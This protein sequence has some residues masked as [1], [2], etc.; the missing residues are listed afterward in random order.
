M[1]R[2]EVRVTGRAGWEAIPNWL[3]TCGLSSQ[4]VHLFGYLRSHAE[5]YRARL[6]LRRVA[7]DTGISVPTIRKAAADLAALGIAS[8]DDTGERWVFTV[9]LDRLDDVTIEQRR[10]VQDLTHPR[11]KS[12]TPPVSNF[13]RVEDQG[14]DQGE[15][16][17][18]TSDDRS[19]VTALTPG[20]RAKETFDAWVSWHRTRVGDEHAMPTMMP[21]GACMRVL[22]AAY[23]AGHDRAVIVRA[24]ERLT[25]RGTLTIGWLE[26]TIRELTP[27]Q[28]IITT[29]AD[30]DDVTYR[31]SYEDLEP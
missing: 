19:P 1:T 29:A 15:P 5:D 25:S 4:A 9:D 7:R 14:E 12:D 23:T 24:L 16:S 22:T 31:T 17:S 8:V 3:W 18:S 10:G 27:V 30:R 21:P 13:A 26:A 28:R 2:A 6:S 11:A 20:Q